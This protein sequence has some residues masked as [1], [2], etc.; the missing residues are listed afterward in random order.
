MRVHLCNANGFISHESPSVLWL[1]FSQ[2]SICV[3]DTFLTG[4]HLCMATFLTRIP[5]CYGYLS[6]KNP[7]VL[8]VPFS[9]ES[10][11]VMAAV[12]ILPLSLSPSLS[13]AVTLYDFTYH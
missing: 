10:V 13:L 11:C 6:H 1:P 2:E 3:M 5:M 12:L 9:Q 8:W 7:S 4:I